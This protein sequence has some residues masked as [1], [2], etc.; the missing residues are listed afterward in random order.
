MGRIVARQYQ[1]PLDRVWIAC[2]EGIGLTIVRS[3]AV[4]ASVNSDGLGVLT[5]GTAE[6]LD[7][8]DCLAQMVFHEICHALVQVA[9]DP[10]AMTKRDWGLDNRTERDAPRERATLR[11]QA[12]IAR[13]HG[14]RIFFAPT[15]DYRTFFDSLLVDPLE[16][17]PR[18]EHEL[19]TDA[20]RRSRGKP[21]SP[22]LDDALLATAAVVRAVSPFRCR[23]IASLYDID[24]IEDP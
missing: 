9:A 7:A 19:A 2:A 22:H 16:G 20:L 24:P 11:V 13:R 12:E 5:L 14:L 23:G 3:G 8:D 4:Y 17:A 21:F 1:D 15:T 18:D 6:T 10:D